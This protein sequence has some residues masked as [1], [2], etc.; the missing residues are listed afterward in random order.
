LEGAAKMVLR[1]LFEKIGR[2]AGGAGAAPPRSW[3]QR[4][5]HALGVAK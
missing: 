1:M 4:L 3:W 5:L 2:Q